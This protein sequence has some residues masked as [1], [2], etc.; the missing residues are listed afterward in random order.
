MKIA[1]AEHGP[2]LCPEC[3]QMKKALFTTYYCDCTNVQEVEEV[4]AG[5]D[6]DIPF[7]RMNAAQ[8]V[9][10]RANHIPTF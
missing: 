6:E 8:L 7:F 9:I 1:E 4:V 2:G 5:K 3:G 10:A